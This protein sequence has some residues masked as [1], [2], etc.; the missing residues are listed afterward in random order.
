MDYGLLR[1]QGHLPS[2][3][4]RS[5]FSQSW[6]GHAGAVSIGV[7]GRNDRGYNQLLNALGA[8][9]TCTV[10][11]EG[12]QVQGKSAVEE[13]FGAERIPEMERDYSIAKGEY[14]R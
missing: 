6:P 2:S 1:G 5:A 14:D 8:G 4:Q 10:A 7:V 11:A 12:N 9:L 13:G 3:H